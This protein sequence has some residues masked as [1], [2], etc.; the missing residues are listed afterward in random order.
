T[1]DVCVAI[2]QA[3]LRDIGDLR[4]EDDRINGRQVRAGDEDGFAIGA[5]LEIDVP[6]A[7][8]EVLVRNELT[9]T[10][11]RDEGEWSHPRISAVAGRVTQVEPAQRHGLRFW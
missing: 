11:R 1:Y 9:K 6:R 3:S 5:E 8:G 7:L 2:R 10:P 4:A